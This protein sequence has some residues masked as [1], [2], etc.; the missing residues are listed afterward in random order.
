MR[1]FKWVINGNYKNS[2]KSYY[3]VLPSQVLFSKSCNN[4]L[5]TQSWTLQNSS[6]CLLFWKKIVENKYFQ[7]HLQKYW[8]AGKVKTQNKY[9][10]IGH[11]KVM[12]SWSSWKNNLFITFQ[13]FHYFWSFPFLQNR[14]T[15]S[16]KNCFS[17]V[18]TVKRA[19]LIWLSI[20]MFGNPVTLLSGFGTVIVIFGVT[21]YNKAQEY[22]KL[23]KSTQVSW[24]FPKCKRK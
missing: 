22:D 1:L 17:V 4:S 12:N 9:I 20:I 6:L 15:S 2:T 7:T 10:C 3:W 18:N 14:D 23:H 19:F 21:L 13:F 8:L 16:F 24:L 11:F 5:S